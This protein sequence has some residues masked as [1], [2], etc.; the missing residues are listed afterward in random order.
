MATLTHLWRGFKAPAIP[1]NTDPSR[2]SR[3]RLAYRMSLVALLTSVFFVLY[4]WVAGEALLARINLAMTGC[5]L[6]ALLLLRANRAIGKTLLVMGVS[7]GIFLVASVVGKEAGN[8][9]LYFPVICG[10]FLLFSIRELPALVGHLALPVA[11]LLVL[12]W[13]DY[14]LLAAYRA[15]EADPI[16]A[17]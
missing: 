14:G 2:A 13:T 1:L 10:I 15:A 16:T 5:Y 3:Q 9:L 6:A 7:L 11:G 17:R 4:N 12:Q 8:Y